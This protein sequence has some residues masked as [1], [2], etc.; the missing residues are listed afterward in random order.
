M[1]ITDPTIYHCPS[2]KKPIL[3]TC[4]TSYTFYTCPLYS[5]GRR[6]QY[7]YYPLYEP[8]LAKCPY[9]GTLFF[10]HNLKE[11]EPKRDKLGFNRE[12]YKYYEYIDEPTL[13]D[14]IKAIKKKL[15]KTKEEEIETR[16]H[17]WHTL[18]KLTLANIAFTEDEMKLW[19]DNN[20]VQLHLLEPTLAEI[21]NANGKDETQF[22]QGT[23]RG[24]K[25]IPDKEK[26]HPYSGF[27]TPDDYRE[28]LITT[29]AE[30]HR[31]LEHYDQCAQVI[32][33]LPKEKKWLKDQYLKK[34]KSRSR[35][36]FEI[37][38]EKQ[39]KKAID[40]DEAEY[41]HNE[42]KYDAEI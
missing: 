9:C 21:Q 18:N 16:K 3:Q 35:F 33:T 23:P 22:S 20:T 7:P 39:H 15:Y 36:V 19:Q 38:P 41:E 8:D 40:T 5:D 2:C 12:T 32:K 1:D 13:A 37:K 34:C 24:M 14:Y 30:L 17:L 4:Y 10:V 6:E 42:G 31:S 29:I 28:H 26:P 11:K 25:H 27:S